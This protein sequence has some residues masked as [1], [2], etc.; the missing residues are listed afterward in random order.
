MVRA[1]TSKRAIARSRERARPCYWSGSK[2][3]TCASDERN[4]DGEKSSDSNVASSPC[5]LMGDMT[6]ILS[7][8]C[9]PR[10]RADAGASAPGNMSA[11]NGD[12][13]DVPPDAAPAAGPPA[14]PNPASAPVSMRRERF[15]VRVRVRVPL[16]AVWPDAGDGVAVAAPSCIGGTSSDGAVLRLVPR[17]D[18][19]LAVLRGVVPLP[20]NATA[21]AAW[22][23]RIAWRAGWVARGVVALSARP[24]LAELELLA[25]RAGNGVGALACGEVMSVSLATP[26]SS[27]PCCCPDT[28]PAGEAFCCCR[29]V[30]DCR[31]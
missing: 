22:C 16:G 2:V 28:A 1:R 30:A 14:P 24:R 13:I 6:S 9:W 25:G 19:P 23:S 15:L 8:S 3:K 11:V 17:A 27:T 5:M 20:G 21:A 18:P 26:A 10:P 12:S 31:G 7:A 4:G 29:G